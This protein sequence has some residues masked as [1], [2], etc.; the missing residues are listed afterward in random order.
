MHLPLSRLNLGINPRIWAARRQE[1]R[2]LVSRRAIFNGRTYTGG[3]AP[4]GFEKMR[5]N[6]RKFWYFP[7]LRFVY[8]E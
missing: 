2:P 7:A 5:A 8:A 1:T 4:Q 6:N 3:L